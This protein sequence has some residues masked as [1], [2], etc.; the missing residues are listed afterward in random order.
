MDALPSVSFA[1]AVNMLFARLENVSPG[2]TQTRCA[3]ARMH[4][5][6]PGALWNQVQICVQVSE[7]VIGGVCVG[8]WHNM[9]WGGTG[10]GCGDALDL[11]N[12]AY[13]VY[14]FLDE[15]RAMRS[16]GIAGEV[17]RCQLSTL[18]AR[19][20]FRELTHATVS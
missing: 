15:A 16:D 20:S 8:K 4:A 5:R 18:V 2:Q 13:F 6:I 10:Q 1:S 9:A 19:E 12:R 3:G 11:A 17:D 7:E 14:Q